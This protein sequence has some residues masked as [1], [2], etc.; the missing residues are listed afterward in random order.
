MLISTKIC[1]YILV[2]FHTGNNPSKA[3]V[4]GCIEVYATC[5][6]EVIGEYANAMGTNQR[7]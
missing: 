6:D 1:T 4:L 3:S 7:C 2:R 5:F